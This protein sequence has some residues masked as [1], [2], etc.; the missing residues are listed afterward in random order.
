MGSVGLGYVVS[1]RE[2]PPSRVTHAQVAQAEP[3]VTDAEPT[4]SPSVRSSAS[5][6]TLASP[7]QSDP[8]D[9]TEAPPRASTPDDT[10][11]N[12][13]DRSCRPKTLADETVETVTD[14]R[15][16]D[17]QV[18]IGR[19]GC[20]LLS[21]WEDTDG[22]IRGA[23]CN[24]TACSEADITTIDQPMWETECASSYGCAHS[25]LA[26]AGDGSP[27][28]AYYKDGYRL[29]RCNDASCRTF[30]TQRFDD[31]VRQLPF[32][33]IAV[34]GDGIATIAYS[35][36]KLRLARCDDVACSSITISTVEDVP[37]LFR[38][39]IRIG[40]DGNFVIAG[41]REK[42]LGVVHCLDASC[43]TKTYSTPYVD[44]WTG[45]GL[46]SVTI[47]ALGLPLI[48]HWD[49]DL[50]VGLTHCLDLGCT[51][52]TTTTIGEQGLGPSNIVIRPDGRPF[53]FS[54]RI[55]AL[56]GVML[57]CVDLACL[58]AVER[59]VEPSFYAAGTTTIDTQG[60]VVVAYARYPNTDGYGEIRVMRCA[61]LGC[62]TASLP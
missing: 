34:D 35:N 38:P 62:T 14:S 42:V 15:P 50:S 24:N 2:P 19:D 43:G 22:T 11:E 10:T 58:T 47:D 28:I 41:G 57:D 20:P 53:I 21:Y 36:D 31:G 37:S 61:A 6:A 18:A 13:D 33:S 8:P 27:L 45:P 49:F 5:E 40:V 4:S 48:M 46:T 29:A 3:E 54:A 1:V 39:S 59:V 17:V 32:M 52:A 56:G 60:R 51:T 30:T 55:N 25:S 7:E 44:E 12:A 26:I 23:H 9:E 16:T